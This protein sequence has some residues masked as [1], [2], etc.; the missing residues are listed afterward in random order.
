MDNR[1]LKRTLKETGI[2][3]LT[4]LAYLGSLILDL[5][6]YILSNTKYL[7]EKSC[8]AIAFKKEYGQW[9][10]SFDYDPDFWAIFE[11]DYSDGVTSFGKSDEDE[12]LSD[13][14]KAFYFSIFRT[15]FFI[16]YWIDKSLTEYLSKQPIANTNNTAAI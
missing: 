10:I 11:I 12:Y 14:C 3:S 8:K 4:I 5:I 1:K 6:E 2:W 15:R 9:E 13:S 7:W 16:K